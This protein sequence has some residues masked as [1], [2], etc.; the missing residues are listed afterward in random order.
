ME[1]SYG[2]NVETVVDEGQSE[3]AE[4]PKKKINT[5]SGRKKKN[6]KS[7]VKRWVWMVRRNGRPVS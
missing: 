1:D 2:S 6:T 5:E 4:P 3:T 7:L